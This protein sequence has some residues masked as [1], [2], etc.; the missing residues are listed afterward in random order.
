VIERYKLH[1]NIRWPLGWLEHFISTPGSTTGTIRATI[2]LT[3]ISSM[4]PVFDRIF[5][6]SYMPRGAWPPSYG[7]AAEREPDA[8]G[9]KNQPGR[10]G[11][12]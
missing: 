4:L 3:I 2:I 11:S 6:T 10:A 8:A 9:E 12:I 7:I 1:A 5:G